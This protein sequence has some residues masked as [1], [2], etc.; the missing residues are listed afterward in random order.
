MKFQDIPLTW[1]GCIFMALAMLM[2]YYDLNGFAHT[3]L[4]TLF[5]YFFH[6]ATRYDA[7]RG[8]K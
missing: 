6:K 1:L 7:I 2:T 8:N 5:G 4:G 3:M